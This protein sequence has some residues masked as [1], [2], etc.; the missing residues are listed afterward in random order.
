MPVTKLNPKIGRAQVSLANGDG[1]QK[2]VKRRFHR[3][4]TC[5]RLRPK[6]QL[7]SIQA[8]NGTSI[9]GHL[10]TRFLTQQSPLKNPGSW[11]NQA[12]HAFT[13]FQNEHGRRG[14]VTEVLE[15]KQA[16]FSVKPRK[17]SVFLRVRN[18]KGHLLEMNHA[19]S[20]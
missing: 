2:I 1:R 3:A 9:L 18:C 4:V 14:G 13:N 5:A 17:F 15:E 19:E 11:F 20:G 12:K 8:P 6:N 10:A 16:S 7:S